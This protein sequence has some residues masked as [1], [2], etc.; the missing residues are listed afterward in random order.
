M[1]IADRSSAVIDQAAILR[2]L[3]RETSALLDRVLG[4]FLEIDLQGQSVIDGFT[5]GHV[6]THLSREGDRMADELLEAT[7]RAVPAFDAERR[8]DVEQGGLRPGA[9]L[10]EDFE[11]SSER[12]RDAI[13]GVDDWSSQDPAIRILP[14]QRLLQLVIHH[15]DLTRPWNSVPEEDAAIALSQLPALMP[16]DL[17]GI[18][19]VAR[20]GLPLVSST[21]DDGVAVVEGDP[22]SL[23]AWVSGRG[24]VADTTEPA[25]PAGRRRTWF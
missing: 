2:S 22:R 24:D 10:I 9:V 19:L 13:S 6:L 14:A 23:L 18:R 12:L 11:E 20:P 7:G 5:G 1:A 21:T 25:I 8:W 16:E 17:A 3:D 4:E 15:A